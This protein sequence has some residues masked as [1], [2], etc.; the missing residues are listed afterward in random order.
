MLLMDHC[1]ILLHLWSHQSFPGGAGTDG[2][3]QLSKFLSHGAVQSNA[4]P[5]VEYCCEPC[6]KTFK[7]E[8][9]QTPSR[10]EL[11]KAFCCFR[12]A[13]LPKSFWCLPFCQPSPFQAFDQHA[14]SKKH[15]QAEGQD[16][17]RILSLV[18]L[19]CFRM[20]PC[21]SIYVCA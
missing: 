17:P 14:K 10:I 11:S 16:E 13:A 3:R 15:L 6:R 20:V 8:K 9:V 2:S 7:S 1:C 19:H 12:I 18:F 21:C 4:Y 5:K